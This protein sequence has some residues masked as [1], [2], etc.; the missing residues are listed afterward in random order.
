MDSSMIH[1]LGTKHKD[2]TEKAKQFEE[3]F[4]I[5]NR[6]NPQ[7]DSVRFIHAI[8]DG[9]L[10]HG[11]L[12]IKNGFYTL[13]HDAGSLFIPFPNEKEISLKQVV[14]FDYAC[15]DVISGRFKEEIFEE[16]EIEEAEF[17]IFQQ[18]NT[19]ALYNLYVYHGHKLF[20]RIE[21]V[22]KQVEIRG[23]GDFIYAQRSHDRYIY[24]HIQ[25]SNNSIVGI[26]EN[27]YSSVAKYTQQKELID[28]YYDKIVK[29]DKICCSF[30][31][32]NSKPSLVLE[33]FI[34]NADNKKRIENS[35]KDDD[36]RNYYVEYSTERKKDIA[37]LCRYVKQNFAG[38]AIYGIPVS[39]YANCLNDDFP[40]F[41]EH[42][43]FTD[44]Q[45]E[46]FISIIKNIYPNEDYK[47][48]PENTEYSVIPGLIQTMILKQWLE[49]NFDVYNPYTSDGYNSSRLK[50][51]NVGIKTIYNDLAQQLYAEGVLKIKWISEYSLFRISLRHYN[52][53]LYQYHPKWLGKQSVDI[54]IP[55]LNIG[56]EYQGQQHYKAIDYFGGEEG[57][58]QRKELDGRKRKLCMDNG[59]TLV[60]WKYTKAVS[61]INFITTIEEITELRKNP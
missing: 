5:K 31:I 56:I 60:E 42:F 22:S 61:D 15:K 44:R 3:Y 36:T 58:N 17:Y 43:E 35:L 34:Q 52:D 8:V 19:E 4:K 41:S 10:K 14:C 45:N 23:L 57:L 32:D 24:H 11:T 13:E 2:I 39:I 29:K 9:E 25:E 18:T 46:E 54:F 30:W 21:N 26:G 27:P 16:G 51:I 49:D 40:L 53:S 20:M 6:L 47:I 59:V 1:L 48:F 7:R 33:R 50:E 38:H 12:V 28:L 55:C 37:F